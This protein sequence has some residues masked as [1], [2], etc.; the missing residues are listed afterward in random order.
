[1]KFKSQVKQ[2]QLIENITVS[3]AKN[4]RIRIG[5]ALERV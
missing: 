1:M 4:G 2:N 3:L 5:F